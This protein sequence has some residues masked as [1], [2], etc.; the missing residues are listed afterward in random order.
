MV[1]LL[2]AASAGAWASTPAIA[3]LPV[4][5]SPSLVFGSSNS[6]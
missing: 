1:G 2:T 3:D 5:D 6:G 4:F